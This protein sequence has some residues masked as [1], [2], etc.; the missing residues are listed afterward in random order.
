MVGGRCD[1]GRLWRGRRCQSDA[2]I[3]QVVGDDAKSDPSLDAGGPLV[4]T[5]VQAVAA[6][7]QADA[8]LAAGAPLLRA[9]EPTLFVQ[10]AT[11]GALGARGWGSPRA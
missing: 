5:S 1:D 3:D 9:A 6:L 10:P 8:P 4:A 2:D 11:V 7:E